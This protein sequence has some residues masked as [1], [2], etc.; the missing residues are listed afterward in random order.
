MNAT[1]DST[2]AATGSPTLVFLVDDHAFFR[3][4]VAAWLQGQKGVACCGEAATLQDA[5]TALKRVAPD[6]LLL[7]LGF[8]EG[9]GLDFIPEAMQLQ[10]DIRVVVL[11]QRDEAVFAERAIRAG[12]SGYLMKT[13]AVEQLLEAIRTVAAG[14]TYLSRAARSRVFA[15]RRSERMPEDSMAGLSDRE[16]QV[17]GLIGSGCGPAEIAARLSISPKTVE[18]YRDHLKTKFGVGT[19]ARLAELATDWVHYGRVPQMAE[20]TTGASRP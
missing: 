3:A 1:L 5:R 15:A 14:G 19:A 16:L 13:E 12:A 2:P 6:V 10:P 9:D 18:T 8:H 17:F 11:S 7:D 20:G 4:G